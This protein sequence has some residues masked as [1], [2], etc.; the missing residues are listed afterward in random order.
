MH[1]TKQ[2]DCTPIRQTFFTKSFIKLISP[3]II[4]AK[5]SRYMVWYSYSMYSYIT[6]STQIICDLIFKKLD[7]IGEIIIEF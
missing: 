5:H 2:W 3:K 7:S 1:I 6:C 4:T